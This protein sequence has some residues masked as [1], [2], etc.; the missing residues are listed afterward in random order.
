MAR[1]MGS[2]EESNTTMHTAQSAQ[3]HSPPSGTR[4]VLDKCPSSSVPARSGTDA[5]D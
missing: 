1:N 2:W 4:V 3:G 5:L